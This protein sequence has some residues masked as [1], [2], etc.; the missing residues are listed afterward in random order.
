MQPGVQRVA[1]LDVT[2][3][4]TRVGTSDSLV[5]NQEVGGSIPL[6][7]GGHCVESA[8]SLTLRPQPG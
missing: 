5:C 7:S 2:S 3:L 4:L 8:D 1:W 6:V